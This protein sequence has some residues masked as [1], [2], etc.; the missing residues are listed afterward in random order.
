MP[1][2]TALKAAVSDQFHHPGRW[3]NASA[4][5]AVAR[6]IGPPLGAARRSPGE[7]TRGTGVPPAVFRQHPLP[8]MRARTVQFRID[9]H[10]RRLVA[11]LDVCCGAVPLSAFEEENE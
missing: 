1:K 5:G 4:L 7:T 2:A 11:S 9:T 10:L 6:R 8:S 3:A